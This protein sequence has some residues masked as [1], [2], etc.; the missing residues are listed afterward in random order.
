MFE[1]FSVHFPQ[2]ILQTAIGQMS[3]LHLADPWLKAPELKSVIHEA[4]F[5]D[6]EVISEQALFDI[7]ENL[8]EPEIM[9]RLKA[10]AAERLQDHRQSDG[11]HHLITALV[12]QA[13]AS[14]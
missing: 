11:Y 8:T 14:L 3:K 6:V 7:L 5:K 13:T 10:D 12:A 9:K 4:G 2:Q 1:L